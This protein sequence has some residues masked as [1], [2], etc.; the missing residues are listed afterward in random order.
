M[1]EPFR[2]RLAFDP[3][4]VPP[5][6]RLVPIRL[7][8]SYIIY[9]EDGI[10][11]ALNCQTGEVEF[12]DTDAT[13]VI[14]NAINAIPEIGQVFLKFGL[15]KLTK[16][17]ILKNYVDLVGETIR[18]PELRAVSTMDRMIDAR[19]VDWVLIKNL[20]LNGNDLAT[21]AIDHSATTTTYTFSHFDHLHIEK[22]IRGIDLTYR[23]GPVVTYVHTYGDELSGLYGKP[24]SGCLLRVIGGVFGRIE[25]YRGM[26]YFDTLGLGRADIGGDARAH[27]ANCDFERSVGYC[28]KGIV[29]DGLKPRVW[30]VDSLLAVLSPSVEPCVVGDFE[31]LGIIGGAMSTEGDFLIDASGE[32]LYVVEPVEKYREKII[33]RDGWTRIFIYRPFVEVSNRLYWI[34]TTWFSGSVGT[35][36]TGTGSVTFDAYGREVI[37]STGTTA[38]SIVIIGKSIDGTLPAPDWGKKRRIVIRMKLDQITNQVIWLI[39][40]NLADISDRFDTRQHIGFVIENGTIYASCADGTTQSLVSLGTIDTAKHKLEVEFVPPYGA[41]FF[42]DNVYKTTITANLPSGINWADSAFLTSAFNTAAENKVLHIYSVEF[43]QEA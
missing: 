1:V 29:Y 32:D 7:P 23:D 30:V 16:P 13:T 9:I 10:I 26:L 22:C 20:L 36:V 18:P 33:K 41:R 17:I 2:R 42:I 39:T 28:L 3:A 14:Q 19:A 21:T 40:G 4:K 6:A 5:F 24:L 11:K 15:Y 34:C 31:M 37:L 38:S 27:F 25:L 35:Y 12:S 8:P 43:V